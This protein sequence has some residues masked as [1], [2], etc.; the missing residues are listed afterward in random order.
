MLKD[1]ERWF[2]ARELRAGTLE[3][4][5]DRQRMRSAGNLRVKET[6]ASRRIFD[7]PLVGL[8]VD[9]EADAL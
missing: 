9:L 1:H 6:D 4:R 2:R 7:K 5:A 8:A 3:P